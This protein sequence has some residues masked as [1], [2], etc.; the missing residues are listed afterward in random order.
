MPIKQAQWNHLARPLHMVLPSSSTLGPG[1]ERLTI[2]HLAG[3]FRDGLKIPKSS[4]GSIEF[5]G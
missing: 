3:S 2:L 4:L 5:H 1:L